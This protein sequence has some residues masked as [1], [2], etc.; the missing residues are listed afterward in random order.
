MLAA[1]GVVAA[2]AFG[3]LMNLSCWPF[4]LG[5]A[6]PGHEGS[7]SYVAGRAGAREPAPVPRLHAAHV[8][9]RLGHRPR[10]H[11]RRRDRGARP[12]GPRRRCAGPPAGRRVDDAA[13]SASGSMTQDPVVVRRRACRGRRGCAWSATAS[14]SGATTTVRSRPYSPDEEVGRAGRP[15]R[16]STA[17]RHSR[18]PRSAAIH[19]CAVEVGQ[20]G[21]RRL[22]GGP[23]DLRVDE[24]AGRR[25]GPRPPA[26]RSCRPSRSG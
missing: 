10:D 13:S 26:S 12:G 17:I 23:D 11:Q 21:G 4:M 24:V 19:S 1:Y 5:I 16:P 14:P 25:R 3:L 8:D 22:V 20:P 6:V 9:R 15:G 18:S 7:L 2:Y